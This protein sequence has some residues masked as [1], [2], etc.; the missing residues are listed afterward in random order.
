MEEII[1]NKEV[2]MET[3]IKE[4]MRTEQAWWFVSGAVLATAF[5]I[6][7]IGAVALLSKIG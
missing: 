6:I 3:R 1:A 5:N 2:S 7:L 4:K